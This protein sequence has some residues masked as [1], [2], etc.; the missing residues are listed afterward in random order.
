MQLL[1]QVAVE[2]HN[3]DPNAHADIRQALD[4][5]LK[6]TVQVSYNGG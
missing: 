6:A 1:S 5:T 2:H 4:G 3:Q